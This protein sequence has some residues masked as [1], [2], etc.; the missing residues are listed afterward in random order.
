LGAPY[1]VIEL[2]PQDNVLVVGPAEALLH[3]ACRL[4]NLTFVRSSPPAPGF[5]AEV[6]IRYRAA[7]TPAHI[8]IEPDQGARVTFETPQRG[9]APG[10]SVVFYSGDEILGGG[11]ISSEC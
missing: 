7:R 10:Q 5:D 11:L 4:E 9:L 1:Y 8:E 2:R 6:R 3:T